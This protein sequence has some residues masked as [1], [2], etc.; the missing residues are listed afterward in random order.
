MKFVYYIV[1]SIMLICYA[2]ADKTNVILSHSENIVQQYPDSALRILSEI[3]FPERLTDKQKADYGWVTATAHSKQDIAM[4][5]DSLILLSLEYYK[6]NSIEDKLL[7]SY[8]L[9]IIHSL[10]NEDIVAVTNLIEEGLRL[11]KKQNDSI[12]IAEFYTL[13]A[14]TQPVNEAIKSYRMIKTYNNRLEAKAD[15]MIALSYANLGNIDSAKHYFEKSIEVAYKNREGA[16]AHYHRNYADYLY[17]LKDTRGALKEMKRVLEYAPD[18]AN[19]NL[20]TSISIIYLNQNKTDSAQYYLDKAKE[21]YKQKTDKDLPDYIASNN[22]IFSSQIMIDFSKRH[23]IDNHEFMRYND[24]L[25]YTIN[26]NKNILEGQLEVKHQLEQQNL[27]LKIKH[28]NTQLLL[29][30]LFSVFCVLACLFY[31]YFRNRKQ[32]LQEIE[33]KNETLERLLNDV[34]KSEADANNTPDFFKKVLLQQLGLIRL[35]ATS[36]TSQNQALL[37][38][39]SLITNEE[40]P[41]D[42]LLVWDDLYPVIDSV[43]DNFY[44]ITQSKYNDVLID[45]E[46]QLCCLLCAEFSTKEISVVTQQSVRT[47]YQRKTTIRQ[48]LQM[49]EKEDIVNFIKNKS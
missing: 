18:Y 9:A 1:L 22:M 21:V 27:K 29:T 37:Q 5:N 45:K 11:A 44:S 28:Q 12:A 4:N 3:D 34:S 16:A 8:K 13:E 14:E 30:I 43:Y 41:T 47:I 15:Y 49:D 26:K 20:Y 35:V 6:K 7:S 39:I 38:Q 17:A 32:R 24:S 46:M 42:S 2:C 31:I 19:S 33:E 40:L 48:K 10:W 36:P 23:Y 25:S